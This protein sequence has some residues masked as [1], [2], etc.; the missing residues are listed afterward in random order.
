MDSYPATKKTVSKLKEHIFE[1]DPKCIV[2]GDV[3]HT[4]IRSSSKLYYSTH[5][6]NRGL[7]VRT[8]KRVHLE[9][10]T[11]VGAQFGYI[12]PS[13][14][15]TKSGGGPSS[16]FSVEC[17]QLFVLLGVRETFHPPF[18]GMI[19]LELPARSPATRWIE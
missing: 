3:C 15:A 13:A 11:S 5:G 9:R 12:C 16:Q 6:I 18:A 1:A 17:P 14:Q 19:P 8:V 10:L 4:L 7:S 2:S